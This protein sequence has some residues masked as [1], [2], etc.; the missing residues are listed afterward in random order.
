MDSRRVELVLA[1]GSKL[2]FPYQPTN[3]LPLMLT[4]R[5]FHKSEKVVGLT[6]QDQEM[7]NDLN[8]MT[9]FLAV[10]DERN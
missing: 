7:L 4:T 2:E 1:N 6:F 5:H 3:N 9:T 8:G 10:A